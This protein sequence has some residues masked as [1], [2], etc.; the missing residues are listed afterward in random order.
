MVVVVVVVV[1]VQ[2]LGGRGGQEHQEGRQGKLLGLMEG[3]ALG[4][5][6]SA[7][8]SVERVLG[9]VG[10]GECAGHLGLKRLCCH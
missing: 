7:Q 8:G 9:A 5:G 6:G 1:V 3:P 10:S 4:G 2:Q